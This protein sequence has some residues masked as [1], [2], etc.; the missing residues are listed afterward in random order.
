M[1]PLFWPWSRL[2]SFFPYSSIKSLK[3]TTKKLKNIK[4]YSWSTKKEGRF[5]QTVLIVCC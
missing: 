4:N 2:V 3:K 1:G 5:F